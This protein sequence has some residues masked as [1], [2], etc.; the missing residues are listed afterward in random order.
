MKKLLNNII[1]QYILAVLAASYLW[2]C[3]LTG[4]WRTENGHY[5]RDSVAGGAMI[6]SFWHSRLTMTAFLWRRYSRQRIRGMISAHGDGRMFARIGYFIRVKAI[7]GSSR[8]GGLTA[9][10]QLE[11]SLQQGAA[12]AITPDGP[13][14]PKCRVKPGIILAAM[15]SGAPIVPV[16]FAMSRQ[17]RLRSWDEMVIPLPFARGVFVCGEPMFVESGA[18]ARLVAAELETRINAVTDRAEDLAAKKP[19]RRARL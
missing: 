19:A 15:R 1:I 11:L 14:G 4:R 17:L 18:D 3:Y 16:A 10:R 6:A 8:R 9:L 12:A 5:M 7:Y 2:F 13:R